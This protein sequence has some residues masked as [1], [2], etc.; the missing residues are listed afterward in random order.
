MANLTPEC[1][2]VYGVYPTDKVCLLDVDGYLKQN[3]LP[4]PTS[5]RDA[6]L[7]RAQARDALYSDIAR[8][9]PR[10][11]MFIIHEKGCEEIKD[12]LLSAFAR[13]SKDPVFVKMVIEFASAEQ[14][15]AAERGAIGALFMTFASAELEKRKTIEKKM[16]DK[17]KE[18]IKK[19]NAEIEQGIKHLFEGSD[20]LLASY[21]AGVKSCVTNLSSQQEIALAAAIALE[22]QTSITQILDMDLPVTAS[23]FDVSRTPYYILEGALLMEK[24]KFSKYTSTNQTAFLESL[25]RW[26]F[27]GLN[28]MDVNTI[29]QTVTSIY[30]ENK[31]LNAD[32]YFINIRDCGTS[33][34]NLHMI[35]VQLICG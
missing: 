20:L 2:H 31:N 15:E 25:K 3:G 28:R 4:T 23:V 30:G 35:A 27:E 16:D 1:A 8:R 19:Q 21:I 5:S 6:V 26:V 29:W 11:A 9:F 12:A 32:K 33:Y 13:H 24:E 17:E 22:S 14:I 10:L 18:A 7:Q 34:S